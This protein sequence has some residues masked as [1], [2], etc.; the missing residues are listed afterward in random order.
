MDIRIAIGVDRQTGVLHGL[1]FLQ[2]LI[3]L[4]PVGFPHGLQMA[5]LQPA[6]SLTGNSCRLL[7]RRYDILCFA[8][9]MGRVKF[10]A[11]LQQC[12]CFLQFSGAGKP[13]RQIYQPGGYADGTLGKSIGK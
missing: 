2:Y 12:S 5:D 13:S 4:M 9:Q 1:Y 3:Q 10:P 8:P 6:A 11:G 7:Q